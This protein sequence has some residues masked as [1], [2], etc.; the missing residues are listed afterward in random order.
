[1]RTL[2]Q[3]EQF[4]QT[5]SD[6]FRDIQQYSAMFRNSEEIKVY[7]GIFRLIEVYGVISDKFRTLHNLCIYKRAIF[8]T[9]AY[10]EPTTSSK[11]C[12]TFN[13]IGHIQS[14]DIVRT[15][16]SSIFKDVC[17]LI[18]IQPQSQTCN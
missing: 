8:R 5:F 12:Q 10:L 15:V 4:I 1:M 6:I 14:P 9:L 17:L 3:S 2:A 18:H 7:R 16:N 13:M 11:P